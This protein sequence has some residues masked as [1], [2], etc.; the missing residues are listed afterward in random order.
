MFTSSV[1]SQFDFSEL[2][3]DDGGLL[4]E[5]GWRHAKYWWRTGGTGSVSSVLRY[6]DQTHGPAEASSDSRGALYTHSSDNY[7]TTSGRERIR[8]RHRRRPRAFR[9]RCGPRAGRRQAPVAVG[10]DGDSDLLSTPRV[11]PP[12]EVVDTVEPAI[13]LRFSRDVIRGSRGFTDVVSCRTWTTSSKSHMSG[14]VSSFGR[15]WFTDP[16][17]YC[18]GRYRRIL[19]LGHRIPAVCTAV[20]RSGHDGRC[21]S[22]WSR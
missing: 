18:S 3:N 21:E 11:Y 22:T 17:V 15:S 16:C 19:N 10:I 12:P 5:R 13:V 4:N 7:S 9:R 6:Q 14:R 1:R 2:L 20:A 8:K